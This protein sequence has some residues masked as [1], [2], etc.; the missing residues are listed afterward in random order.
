[1]Y[2]INTTQFIV[3]HKLMVYAFGSMFLSS[4]YYKMHYPSPHP[5][6]KIMLKTTLIEY[7]GKQ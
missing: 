6:K 1:M 2:K 4:T 7:K 3:R 5:W